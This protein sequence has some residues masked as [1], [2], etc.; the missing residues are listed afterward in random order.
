MILIDA[1][2]LLYA[3]NKTADAHPQAQQ[4]LEDTLSEPQHVRFSWLTILAFL[5]IT[6]NPRV[7][8]VPMTPAASSAIV[9][10]WL[11][12]PSVAVLEPSERH[13]SILSDLLRTAQARGPLVTD[14]HL[15]ALAIE[16]GA[17]LMT[18]DQDFARFEGLQW[19]NPLRGN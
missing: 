4:W 18:T 2:L 19:K 11:T 3:Y 9:S 12:L 1:N 16:H 7:F 17:T 15:A 14:A 5:R 10:S 8:S 6:T 13:W